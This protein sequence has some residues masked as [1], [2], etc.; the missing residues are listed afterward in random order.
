MIAFTHRPNPLIHTSHQSDI[1]MVDIA[2]KS[3]SPLVQNPAGDFLAAWAPD[4]R[5][6]LYTSSVDDTLSNYY[7]NNQVFIA[8]ING[9]KPVRIGQL[10]DESIGG[11]V[12]N[13]AGI[14]FSAWQRTK[15]QLFRIDPAN[16]QVKP[17]TT[18]NEV[19]GGYSFS[20]DGKP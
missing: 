8:D 16:G 18:T 20:K 3:I 9:G 6:I 5:R 12:W 13:P 7:K 10:F 4:S 1:S 14:F 15:R 11:L 17:V 19:I 2:S